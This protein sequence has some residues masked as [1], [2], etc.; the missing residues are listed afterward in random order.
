MP[1]PKT[2]EQA[3]WIPVAE[4]AHLLGVTPRQ[5]QRREQAGNIEKRF[6]PRIGSAGAPVLYS[7]EDIEALKAGKPN[8]H[9]RAVE[10]DHSGGLTE[11]ARGAGKST[12]LALSSHDT[13]TALARVT[14]SEVLK[15]L[16]E[17]I[18]A[19]RAGPPLEAKPWLTLAEA[20]EYSGLP[21]KFLLS[22]A[23]DGAAFAIDVGAGGDRSY[24]RFSRDGLKAAR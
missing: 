15:S 21:E 8:V 11:M 6:G 19:A 4:A 7:R 18:T 12:A 22:R 1:L 23:R 13:T 3:D 24:W 16:A 14:S 10:P 2:A 9:A 5:V 17:L 20:V